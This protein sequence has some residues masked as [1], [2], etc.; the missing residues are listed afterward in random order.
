M[1]NVD[2]RII[3]AEEYNTS[4]WMGGTTTE[5]SIY[6]T[7]ANYSDRNF[8]WRLSSATVE[9]EESNFT[10]LPDYDRT[11]IVLD[12]EVVLVHKNER[13]IR[14]AQYEQDRFDGNYDTVSYGKITDYNLMVRKGNQ[15][16]AE[17]MPLSAHN[18]VISLDRNPKYNHRSETYYCV[19]G[20]CAIS[21]G[22][23]TCLIR[24]G[25]LLVVTV[26]ED[27]LDSISIMGDGKV[28]RA[29]IYFNEEAIT[30]EVIEELPE[31][32]YKWS[33][34]DV[35][36]A[37]KI[38]YTNFRGSKYIFKSYQNV[39]YDEKLQRSIDWLESLFLPFIIFMLGF[40]TTVWISIEWMNRQHMTELFFLWLLIDLLF[41][42]PLLY[43]L[44]LPKP[45]A[46]HIKKM[47]SLTKEEMAIYE[48]QRSE[49][50][51]L[52]KLLKKYE[53]TGR[54]RYDKD[55]E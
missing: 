4:K 35:I 50:K 34:M 23:N 45:V 7:A 8:I 54:N 55:E 47:G 52:N 17:V 10:K 6:P 18:T 21:F 37:A 19:E 40:I 44:I 36:D 42:N 51:R 14:L 15:G 3:K 53:I 22:K 41:L 28:I 12:N 27:A 32:P 24:K 5:L 11:L 46:A 26:S 49:N 25:E 39:W 20:F 38:C 29:Y 33:F 48:K 13:A 43:Y 9:L 2:F 16:M 1:S 31:E 30:S